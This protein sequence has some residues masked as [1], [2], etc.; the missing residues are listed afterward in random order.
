LVVLNK[1]FSINNEDKEVIN[2]WYKT[3]GAQDYEGA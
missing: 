2:G 3:A 1:Y